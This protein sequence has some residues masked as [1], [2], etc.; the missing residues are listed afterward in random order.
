MPSPD[1]V[2]HQDLLR[3]RHPQGPRTPRRRHHRRPH[4]HQPRSGPAAH[5]HRPHLH[6]RAARTPS[7]QDT[8]SP[9]PAPSNTDTTSASLF[10]PTAR[11]L[12]SA[13]ASVSPPASHSKTAAPSPS[14]SP[15]RPPAPP[16]RSS[17]R[18]SANRPTP[19]SISPTR[20]TSPSPS[21]SPSPS[22]PPPHSH[23]PAQLEIANADET[24]HTTLTV[25]SGS[26]VLQNPHTL[27]ATLDPLKAFG[28]SAFGPLRL[29]PISPD[30]T[31]GDWL[32]LVTLVR[33]PT[34]KD[35][36]CPPDTTQP[37]TISGSSLY[38]VDSIAT[39]ADFT[40]PNHRPRRLRR[41]DPHPCPVQ[42]KT[43]FYL[44]LR[45]DPTASQLRHPPHPSPASPHRPLTQQPPIAVALAPFCCH[46]AGI[47]GC[48]CFCLTF[49][50]VVAPKVPFRPRVYFLRFPPK[51]R[52]SSH[53]SLNLFPTNNIRVAC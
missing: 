8:A 21:N 15:S 10:P 43:G 48:R 27:L 12:N 40:D 38:L 34:L 18:T 37:C 30:G 41:H 50:V 16:S 1:I 35:L 9:T 4:R 14:P 17:A 42:P 31:T 11:P 5:P 7:N 53:K 13:P 22:S 24:L 47:C 6:P 19:P 26:L 32:P 25:A 36:R 2:D 52:I 51:D 33:L 20:T 46:P 3:T 28:T 39:D 49:F 29:R 44:R 23:A 45:D